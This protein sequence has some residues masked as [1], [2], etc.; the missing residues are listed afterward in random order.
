[1]NVVRGITRIKT[2]IVYHL[3]K[4]KMYRT[5]DYEEWFAVNEDEINIELAE[6]GADR[7]MDFDL[8]L[9]LEK[10]YQEYLDKNEETKTG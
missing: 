4:T 3:F 10:R 9:E 5:L 6:N 2:V 8:E 1:M 7:E